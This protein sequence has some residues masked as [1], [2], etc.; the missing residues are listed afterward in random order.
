MGWWRVKDLLLTLLAGQ[1]R[2]REETKEMV[3][4]KVEITAN[5]KL[6]AI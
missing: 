4:E 1:K 3:E 5:Y 2:D 6:K